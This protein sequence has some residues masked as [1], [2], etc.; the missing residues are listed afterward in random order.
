MDLICFCHLRWNFVYQRPQHLLTRFAQK[1]RVIVIEEP[2]MDAQIA[3][4]DISITKENIWIIVP[5]LEPGIDEP[6]KIRQQQNLLRHWVHNFGITKYI[7]WF[8]TPMA[9]PL[10]E[11]L[12]SPEIVVYDCM[13]ELSA[14][15]GAASNIREQEL[16]LLARADLV[17]TGGHS[18]YEAKRKLHRDIYPFPSSIDKQ[19]FMKARSTTHSPGDQENLPGPR[20]G[21]FGVIDERFDI[22]LIGKLS[23]LK[24]DWQFV[25]VGPVVKIDPDSLPR[26]QNI[27]YIGSRTYGDLPS[28]LSG[29]DVALIPFALNE[30]T[31]F[32]SPTKTP[33]Y[34]AGGIPVV[35]S[36]IR[37]VLNPYGEMGLV[38]IANNVLE[39][40]KGI[41]WGFE[42]KNNPGWLE[43]VDRFLAGVS[44]DIT[45]EQM[46]NY[47]E[48]KIVAKQNCNV[49]LNKNEYV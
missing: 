5:H 39:F 2:V 1:Y 33:E 34:L 23:L 14:F 44:W 27:H 41:E 30:S 48:N 12:P 6:E 24:P 16:K 25:I 9:L 15:K 28:Y 4:L 42:M 17:F 22:D 13:D 11:A 31:R 37:D 18:L 19:H 26:S 21:F 36:S 8:Y 29:W 38:Y 46:S 47:I 35:S 3:S 49:S 45:W 10:L 7:G 20:V 43:K 40:I 32:I